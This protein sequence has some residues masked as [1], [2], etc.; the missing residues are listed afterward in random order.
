MSINI[1]PCTL[2]HSLSMTVLVISSL[3]ISACIFSCSRTDNKP[4]SGSEKVTIAYSATTDTVLVEVARARGYFRD[5]GLEVTLRPYP[6]GKPALQ[7]MLAGKADF[8][9]VAETPV[10]FAIMK[11]AGISIIATI[12]TSDKDNAIIA[13]RDKGIR[14]LDDLQGKKIAVTLGTTS[15]FFL[16]AMLSVH[17]VSMKNVEV[18][19]MKAEAMPDALARGDVDALATFNPYLIQSRKKLGDQTIVFYDEN[20]YTWSFNI[21]GTQEFVSKNPTKVRKLLR[22]LMK[23]EEFVRAYPAEAQKIVADSSGVDMG[24]VRD[25]WVDTRFTLTL[26]Q[27]LLL[28]LEDESRWAIKNK[29]VNAAKIPNYLKFIYRDG[30]ESVKPQAVRIVK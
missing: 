10:M 17:G 29:L 2:R 20:V 12:Q 26:D 4:V 24:I 7:D 15:N 6:Y 13:R 18:I 22:A 3:A 30:L 14:T 25:M 27:S 8:A 19:D 21:V 28:S 5:E 11:G 16:N 9:T 23:A 1:G